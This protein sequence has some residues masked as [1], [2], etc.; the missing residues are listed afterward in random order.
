MSFIRCIMGSKILSRRQKEQLVREYNEYVKRYSAHMSDV[1]AAARAAQKII[2]HKKYTLEKKKENLKAD[3]LMWQSIKD[4]LKKTASQI[5]VLR[6]QSAIGSALYGKNTT[7]YAVRQKLEKVYTRHMSIESEQTKKLATFIEKLQSK[8]AGITQDSDSMVRV[9]SSMLGKEV[10]DPFAKEAGQAFKAAFDTL[11]QMYERAGGLIGKIEQYFPQRHNAVVVKKA[12]FDK[13]KSDIIARIDLNRMTD[14]DTGLPFT[15]EKMEQLLP[16]IYSAIVTNGLDAVA[17]RAEAGKTTSGRIGG[18]ALR[19]SHDRFFVFKDADSFLEYNEQYGF[20]NA[21]LFDA[22]MGHISVMSRD[23]A[24]MKELG[25]KPEN[26]FARMNMLAAS[27]GSAFPG[28][29]ETLQG[30]YDVVSGRNGY[31]GVNSPFYNAIVSVQHLVRSALLGA[32]PISSIPDSYMAVAAAKMN[33]IPAMNVVK[34]YLSYF[35]PAD[36]KDRRM[37]RRLSFAA[38]AASGM[39]IQG[40]R[41]TEETGGVGWAAW[42]SN[43]TNR[44]SGAGFMTD[45]IKSV[46]PVET[47]GFLAELKHEGVSFSDLPVNMREAFDRWDITEADYENIMK[48]KFTEVDGS[49]FITPEAVARIN[50]ESGEKLGLWLTDMAQTASN[51]PRLLTRAI[52]TGAAFGSGRQGT[53]GRA[54]WTSLTMLKSYA[55]TVII[56]HTLPTLRRLGNNTKTDRYSRLGAF[57]LFTTLLGGVSAMSKDVAYGKTVPEMNGK[58]LARAMMTGGGFGIFSDFLFSD[59]SRFGNSITETL[60][61]PMVGMTADAFKV[62]KGNFDRTLDPDQESKFMAD[63]YQ[64]GERYVPAIKLWYTRLMLERLF[65]D[66]VEKAVDPNYE[67]RIRR[68]ERKMKKETGQEFWWRPST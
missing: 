59:Q 26:Q 43:F 40:A 30:M 60:F 64:F 57:M 48:A 34:R 65:L 44:A 15:V 4:D 32:V 18:V 53:K 62:V 24:V 39:S 42:L 22:A 54:A 58:F 47:Q 10:D 41:F 66:H 1:D 56:N 16:R 25:P 9:V 46:L 27:N 2:E 28:T 17:D 3:V 33:G 35:N 23:I 55:I 13:W 31:S 5:D 38:S 20:G 29:G 19:H 51:E 6:E 52:S 45:N 14:E 12:G 8:Y 21:G 61:G 7:A 68:Q 63:L 67:T 37:A 49:D 50:L 36:D 11:N